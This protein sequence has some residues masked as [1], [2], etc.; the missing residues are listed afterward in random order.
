MLSQRNSRIL[1]SMAILLFL[2]TVGYSQPQG[3]FVP[4]VGATD[5]F[6]IQP[7]GR[8]IVTGLSN[9][10][11]SIKRLLWNGNDDPSF[12]GPANLTFGYASLLLPDGKVILPGT[13]SSPLL[14]R[15]NAGGS[16][17]GPR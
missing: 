2:S 1:S 7:D 3:G 17:R 9:G 14:R 13:S 5:N 15:L 4:R 11:G 10:P 12:N 16:P 6:F 8:I